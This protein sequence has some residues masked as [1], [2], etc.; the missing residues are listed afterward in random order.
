MRE[1]LKNQEKM[2]FAFGE[3]GDEDFELA[4]GKML[5]DKQKTS[6]QTEKTSGELR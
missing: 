3:E 5:N 6:L 1:M 2:S 4:M